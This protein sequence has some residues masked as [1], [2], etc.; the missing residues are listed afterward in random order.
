MQE[1]DVTVDGKPFKRLDV[2]LNGRVEGYATKQGEYKDYLT[3]SPDLVFPQ[4][5]NPGPVLFAIASYERDKGAAMTIVYPRDRA[6]WNGK[7]FVTVHGRGA[8]FKQGTLKTWNKNLDPAHPAADLNKYDA[9]M[10]SK[11]YVLVKTRRTSAEGLGEIKGTFEDGTPV[12]SLAFNDTTHYITDF[13]DVARQIVADRF[14]QR[15]RLTYFYGHSAGARIGRDLNYTPGLNT[16]RS[17]RR[18]FDGILADDAA[19]GTWLPVLMKDGKDVLFATDAEKVAF[20][21]Q[22][23]IS[24][25]MYNNIWDHKMPPY[26]SLSYLA[27][28]RSNARILR[29]KGLAPAKERMYEIRGISHSGGENLPNGRRGDIEIL[30]LSR[31][32]DRFI[33]ILDAWVDKGANPPPSRSDDRAVGDA[34]GDGVIENPALAFPEI[35]CPLGVYFPYPE[36]TSGTTSFAAFTGA[37]LEPLD[38]R[39][40]FVDMNRNGVW[41]YRE[42]PT[43]AWRRLG[44]LQKNDDLTR[45]RYAV[46]VRR[47]ADELRKGGFFPDRTAAWYVDQANSTDLQP[48]PKSPTQ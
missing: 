17:G 10:L 4:S 8:S 26:M 7:M 2:G 39:K 36:S 9:L 15:P 47:A 24:H 23:D 42:T 6:A 20:V 22:I 31:M 25:Q 29:Q 19:A 35:A 38:G 45:D 34:D 11:G 5:G 30:D 16:D 14:G 37:G 27:N 41:D 12:D 43:E 3:Q 46:C 33:D 32:M 21:P 1:S 28:K 48:R 13:G 40:V 44:L 18:Y